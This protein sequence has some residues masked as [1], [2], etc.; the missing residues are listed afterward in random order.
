MTFN[1]QIR[2]ELSISL[3]E[4]LETNTNKFSPVRTESHFAAAAVTSLFANWPHHGTV[5]SS[6]VALMNRTE[7]KV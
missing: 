1:G 7:K 5:A 3:P 4:T 6:R 2:L